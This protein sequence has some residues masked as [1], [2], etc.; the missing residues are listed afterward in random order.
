M[1]ELQLSKKQMLNVTPGR[2]ELIR[3]AGGKGLERDM[4]RFQR[5]IRPREDA[6]FHS[7]DAA[8]SDISPYSREPMA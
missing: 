4:V 5:P 1:T 3:K 6:G 8:P 7:A 2:S